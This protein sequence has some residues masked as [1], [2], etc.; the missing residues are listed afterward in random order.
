[1]QWL[2]DGRLYAAADEQDIVRVFRTNDS[3]FAFYVF[4]DDVV[5][6]DLAVVDDSTILIALNDHNCGYTIQCLRLLYYQEIYPGTS[7]SGQGISLPM[8]ITVREQVIVIESKH[9]NMVDVWDGRLHTFHKDVKRSFGNGFVGQKGEYLLIGQHLRART[10]AGY[11]ES[12]HTG[13][14]DDMERLAINPAHLC[15][16]VYVTKHT[17]VACRLEYGTPIAS[18]WDRIKLLLGLVRPRIS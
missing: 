16:F 1:L 5:M 10:A 7:L 11:G 12:V 15:E 18:V 3:L 13:I 4:Y 6:V 17:L 2:P 14:Q 9:Y 8:T